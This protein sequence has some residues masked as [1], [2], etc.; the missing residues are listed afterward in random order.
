MTVNAGVT[1]NIQS[2][3]I[4]KFNANCSISVDGTLIADGTETD[5]IYFTSI[6]DDSIGGDTNGDGTGSTPARGNW[7]A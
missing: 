5:R 3:V 2:G 4:V 7:R 1:L 6:K